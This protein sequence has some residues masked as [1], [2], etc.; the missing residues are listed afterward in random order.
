[1]RGE[2][3]VPVGYVALHINHSMKALGT[4]PNT[5]KEYYRDWAAGVCNKGANCKYLH[6]VDPKATASAPIAAKP[7]YH[8]TN[9]PSKPDDNFKHV[10][11]ANR[12]MVG[13]GL[14][15]PTPENPYAYSKKQLKIK[16]SIF[17][18]IC[19]GTA[20]LFGL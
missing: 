11:A 17:S 9:H 8:K 18:N 13:K 16:E 1:M 4:T 15:R 10:T 2:E 19:F 14:G 20:V 5:A 12:Q 7:A 6:K 3:Q